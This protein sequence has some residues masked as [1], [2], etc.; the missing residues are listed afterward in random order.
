MCSRIGPYCRAAGSSNLVEVRELSFERNHTIP[1]VRNGKIV[2]E[3]N[4]SRNFVSTYKAKYS[5]HGKSSVVKLDEQPALLGFG[6]PF[7]AQTKRVIEVQDGV[8]VFSEQIKGRV[9][10]W[11]TSL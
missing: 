6:A 10:S 2:K 11:L 5:K 9:L 3:R 4:G 7:L 1:R 8:D